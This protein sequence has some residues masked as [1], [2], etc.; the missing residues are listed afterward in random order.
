LP[1]SV[2]EAMSAALPLVVTPV[3]ALPEVLVEGLHA[4]FVPVREPAA[5]AEAIGRLAVDPGAR[6]EMGLANRRLFLDSFQPELMI[7]AI[8]AA[9][10]SVLGPRREEAQRPLA[11]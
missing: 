2:L 8:D 3:G 6:L 9:Y 11:S 5:L 10:R 7:E 4:F 1:I